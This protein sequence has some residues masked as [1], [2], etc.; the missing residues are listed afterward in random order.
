MKYKVL[1][2][3]TGIILS[4]SLLVIFLALN[5]LVFALEI[6]LSG[7]GSDTSN[8]VVVD[9][10]T[11][12]QVTQNNN[13]QVS[14]SVV[15]D[16]NTGENVISDS[17]GV[18]SISTGNSQSSLELD[19][20]VNKAAVKFIGCCR[21]ED[22]AQIT[23]NNGG[24][25]NDVV[26]NSASITDMTVAQ[27][28]QITNAVTGKLNTGRNEIHNVI[29]NSEIVTGNAYVNGKIENQNVNSFAVSSGQRDFEINPLIV[30]N[31]SGSSN[32][33]FINESSFVGIV[34]STFAKIINDVSWDANTGENV[35]DNSMGGVKI[36]TGD[37]FIDFIIENIGINSS[38][39]DIK[40]CCEINDPRDPGEN[41]G[42]VDPV[43]DPSSSSSSSSGASS[44]SSSAAG[45]PSVI[46]LSDTSSGQAK[47]LIFFA[48]MTFLVAGVHL[49]GRE[50]FG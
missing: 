33:I 18:G 27:N 37:I 4:T 44:S 12:T 42:G 22:R 35:I 8:N 2:R 28:A 25:Q 9:Q 7:N 14:E 17:G 30:G 40:G 41:I 45:G 20:S 26:V 47:A 10:T 43:N 16:S 23:G 5:P 46:G 31:N 19:T 13:A 38:I 50:I 6:T 48:G 34:N 36:T 24:S 1:I 49:A 21:D 3:S 39:V 15:I 29:G 11:Q 32:K